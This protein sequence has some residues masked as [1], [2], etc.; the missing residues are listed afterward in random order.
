[1]LWLLIELLAVPAPP[2]TGAA[3]RIVLIDATRLKEPGGSG[4]DWRVH[5]GY[6]LLAGR[7]LQVKV[8]D[9]HTAEGFT[10]FGL[11]AG[12]LV[13]ADRGYCRRGQLA[14]VLLCGAQV[15]VRLAV[16][17]VPLLDQHGRPF[18]VVAWLRRQASGQHSCQVAFE[19]AGCLFAGRL[20]ACTLPAEAAERARAKARRKAS[21]KP[22]QLKE[23]TLFLC[24]WLLLFTSLATH[25]WCDQQVLALS[26]ARW[27]IELVIKRDARK[28]SG[29]LNCGARRLGVSVATGQF[30]TLSNDARYQRSICLFMTH[31]MHMISGPGSKTLPMITITS[32]LRIGKLHLS[33][34]LCKLFWSLNVGYC[35]IA[36]ETPSNGPAVVW[37]RVMLARDDARYLSE[38]SLGPGSPRSLVS[39]F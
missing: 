21:K 24:G 7:L 26:R 4:D 5:L 23:E 34:W 9:Q 14:Y 35:P 30:P 17:Q 25:E 8:S 20:I 39:H 18:D 12:D 36:T 13:V 27:Q 38:R 33:N 1:M 16:C 6:D 10:L 32:G 29:S 19:H 28:C 2:S 22:H 3:Q 37:T 11:Q 15:V 31:K